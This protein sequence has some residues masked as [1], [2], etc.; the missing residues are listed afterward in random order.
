MPVPVR[1]LMIAT[2]VAKLVQRFHGTNHIDI[3][4]WPRP[5]E[6]AL[7]RVS[8]D[9]H[10]RD[11]ARGHPSRRPREERGL[12]RMRSEGLNSIV[13]YDWFHG[14]DP[15]FAK[16]ERVYR[17]HE[18]TALLNWYNAKKAMPRTTALVA[19]TTRRI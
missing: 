13:R 2:A 12:L 3:I 8:K 9:G 17:P 1:S 10:K 4:H 6:R 7:A 15:R 18:L 11:R 16:C 19:T 5:E 14:I